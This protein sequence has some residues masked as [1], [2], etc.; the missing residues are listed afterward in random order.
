MPLARGLP[1]GAL[2]L[3]RTLNHTSRSEDKPRVALNGR[4]GHHSGGEENT[5][6]AITASRIKK[7][8]E[9][10]LVARRG[11]RTAP[12]H[13]HPGIDCCY[14]ALR[15]YRRRRGKGRSHNHARRARERWTSTSFIPA[16]Y[17]RF[18]NN[19]QRP[20]IDPSCD[21]HNTNHP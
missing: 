3:P 11:P 21:L 9:S 4:H 2:T 15:I 16:R 10:S 18:I 19:H 7:I 1:A 17:G 12:H 5:A 14:M 20:L 13:W 6:S 8:F